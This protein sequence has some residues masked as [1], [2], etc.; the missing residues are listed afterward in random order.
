MSETGC[1]V[2]TKRGRVWVVPA[3]GIP[4]SGYGGPGVAELCG[5]M[6]AGAR[7]TRGRWLAGR[8]T[9]PCPVLQRPPTSRVRSEAPL[10]GAS[11]SQESTFYLP[12]TFPNIGGISYFQKFLPG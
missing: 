11:H 3:L 1:G 2:R 9:T 6:P 8:P 4:P 5:R 12:R 10:L 7:E